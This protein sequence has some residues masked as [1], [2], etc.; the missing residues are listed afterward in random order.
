MQYSDNNF[1]TEDDFWNRSSSQPPRTEPNSIL[2]EQSVLGGLM[3]DNQKWDL[4]SGIIR[5]SDFYQMGHKLIFRTLA[6]LAEEQKPFDIITISEAL[7]TKGELEDI[8]GLSYLG[9]MA[10]DIPSVANIEHYARLVSEK[11][12][13]RMFTDLASNILASV[14]NTHGCNSED[15][16]ENTEREVLKIAEQGQ[17]GQGNFIAIQPAL[18]M[19]VDKLEKLFEMEGAVTGIATGFSDLDDLTSG[20][21]PSDLIILAGRPSMGKNDHSHEHGGKHCHQ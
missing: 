1:Y 20:L 17:R 8:G 5:E 9:M 14:S 11:S 16:L 4:V 12:K 13:M 19:T 6:K 18:E 10:K 21:Q 3:L 15:I 7:K 2:S